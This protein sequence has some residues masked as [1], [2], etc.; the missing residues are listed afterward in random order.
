[1]VDGNGD[2]YVAGAIRNVSSSDRDA[3]VSKITGSSGA[4]AWI[5][6][7][8]GTGADSVDRFQ[9]VRVSGNS[10]YVVG[11][12]INANSDIVVSRFNATNGTEEWSFMFNGSG[13]GADDVSST[14]SVMTV[15]A[16][17]SFAIGG[18]TST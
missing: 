7:R 3:F 11:N 2:F 12:L 16:T 13:N 15:L 9:N 8:L 18:E 5:T 4:L 1:V 6:N 10:V 14:K 17:D